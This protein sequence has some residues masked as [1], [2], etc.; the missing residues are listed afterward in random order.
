MVYVND[1]RKYLLKLEYYGYGIIDVYHYL[2]SPFV[3]LY[4][5]HIIIG[6]T[7]SLHH[8]RFHAKKIQ[9]S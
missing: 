3:F 8:M 4:Q 9:I 2:F 1:N 7:N 6:A 5:A